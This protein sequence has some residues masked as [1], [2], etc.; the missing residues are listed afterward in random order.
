[1][2]GSRLQQWNHLVENVRISLY[3]KRH[4]LLVKFFKIE[5]GLVAWNDVDGETQTLNIDHNP[6]GWR[7]F[8]YLSK[9]SIKAVLL[10]NGKNFPA[11]PVGRS[12]HK[13]R[14]YENMKIL[15]EFIHYDKCKK[16][17]QNTAASFVNGTAELDHF[18]KL[19]LIV[20]PE[21]LWNRKS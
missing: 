20:L 17:P 14:L 8:I 9:L 7:F 1:L 10:H 21:N 19:K 13:K 11:I 3:C 18:I 15:M 12:V 4:K 2:L 6:L 5:S 16:Y